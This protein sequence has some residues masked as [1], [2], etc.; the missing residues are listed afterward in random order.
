[1]GLTS[2]LL[3]CRQIDPERVTPLVFKGWSYEPDLVKEN[4]EFFT[5]QIGIDVDY[6]MVSGNYHDKMVAL[7]LAQSRMDCCYV[8]DDDFA[9][10]VEA[11]WLRPFNDLPN[12]ESYQ[13][14][15]YDYNMKAM[16]YQG[17][18]YGL[19]YYTDFTVWI[20]IQKC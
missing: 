5:D 13:N 4:I 16:S 7:F 3:G 12:A 14:D 1:M 8:L 18:S 11:G 19:P 15:L 2:G 9:E 6:E 10:W 17:H 20:Y